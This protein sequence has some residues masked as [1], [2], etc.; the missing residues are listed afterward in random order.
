MHAGKQACRTN[1]KEFS[2]NILPP[3]PLTP[4]VVVRGSHTNLTANEP[5]R[6][7]AVSY[8]KREGQ[9][10]DAESFEMITLA[11]NSFQSHLVSGPFPIPH[12]HNA[13]ILILI[14][15]QMFKLV[16]TC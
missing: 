5:Q 8:L 2:R 9:T 16:T 11:P 10:P 7:D 12:S 15:N 3:P 4:A 1:V 13:I 6:F 14:K